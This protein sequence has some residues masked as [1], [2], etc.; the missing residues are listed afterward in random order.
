MLTPE[1]K[2]KIAEAVKNNRALYANNAKQAVALDIHPSVLTR[3][4]NGETEGVL[5]DAKWIGIARRLNVELKNVAEWVTART[6][7][8]N[9]IYAQLQ[10]C[11]QAGLSAILCDLADI[12]KTYTANAYA[13]ENKNT[14]YIDC[15]QVKSKQKLIRQIAKEFGCNHTA[16]YAEVYADLVFY[17]RSIENPLVI[18]DEAGDLDYPAFL[19]LKAL[20]NATE[21][22]CAWYMMG[23]DGLEEKINRN[24]NLKKVGYTEIFSRFGG[25]YQ[26]VV[27]QGKEAR[28]DF[29]L[30]QVA[31]VAKANGINDVQKLYAKCG[32][33]LRSVF[34]EVQKLKVA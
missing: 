13:R 12:G 14:A 25:K 21:W 33:S 24:R 15:S 7:V 23:A 29:L 27:P 4:N 3:I 10:A 28:Q 2:T 26:S 32:N 17:L 20:W 18:L 22:C 9:H 1:L 5:A 31:V 19:E 6:A 16:R 8:Y 34:K 11:Q 30:S